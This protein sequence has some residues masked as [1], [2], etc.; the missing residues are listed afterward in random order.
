MLLDR[1]GDDTSSVD[2]VAAGVSDMS[3]GRLGAVAAAALALIGVFLGGRALARPA[4]RTGAAPRT[5]MILGLIAIALGALIIATSDGSVETG[6]G[7]G[8][9]TVAVVTGL[10]ALVLGRLAR[11]R[12]RRDAA[13]DTAR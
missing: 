7:L 5:G 1:Q 2:M 9:A 13:A 8:G 12:S 6:N 3:P 11:A 10:I 4:G